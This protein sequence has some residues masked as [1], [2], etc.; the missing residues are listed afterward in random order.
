[1]YFG[2]SLGPYLA[3]SLPCLPLALGRGPKHGYLLLDHQTGARL[4]SF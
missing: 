2:V 3:I 1:L 4:G